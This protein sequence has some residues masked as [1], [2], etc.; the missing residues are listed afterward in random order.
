M[1]NFVTTETV[2]A[3]AVADD[4]TF[5]VGYPTGYSQLSFNA[6]LAGSG[7]Y[8]ILNDNDKIEIGDPGI[9]VSFDA[10]YVA[11]TNLTG[12]TIPAG[13]KIGVSLDMV[14]GNDV[15]YLT[16]PITLASVAD[17]DV[18]TE[19]RPGVDGTIEDVCFVTSVAASTASKL[20]T[21]NLEIGTTNVTGGTLALTTAACNAVGKIV[22]GA[23]ITANNVLTRE[24][25][26]SIEASSTTAFVEGAGSV[27]VR[28]RK[29][30]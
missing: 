10:S 3:S 8:I 9:S 6:G 27:I 29:A 2:L 5:T 15:V 13:T 12:A 17:G 16:F 18:V 20:S 1:A 19:F 28:I 26:L 21:L 22:Q 11:I 23:A 14:D 4:A 25:K 30:A 24:S 7:S